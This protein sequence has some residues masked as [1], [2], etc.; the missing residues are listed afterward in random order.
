MKLYMSAFVATMLLV[1]CDNSTAENEQEQLLNNN[2][3]EQ[4]SKIDSTIDEIANN[5]ES[6]LTTDIAVVDDVAKELIDSSKEVAKEA[7]AKNIEPVKTA[8]KE[9]IES[10]KAVA[11]EV[12]EQKVETVATELKAV[13]K[14]S[15]D[16]KSAFN[17]T[18]ASCHGSNAEKVA[19]NASAI[20]TTM[21]ESE[22]KNA[23]RGY[24]DGSYGKNMKALMQGQVKA[25]SVDELDAL[26]TYIASLK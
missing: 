23:L 13:A 19:L 4:I 9:N 18:C 22:I 17:K 8:I 1:G 24:K 7:I 21:S 6:N 20:L 14:P 12:I 11:K 26:A 5:I 16:A 15:F 2:I 25:Y 3:E 10:T